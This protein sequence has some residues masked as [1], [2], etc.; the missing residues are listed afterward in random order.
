MKFLVFGLGSM[1]KRRV[2]CLKSLD[3]HDIYGFDFNIARRKET[4]EKYSIS[5]FNDLNEINF[6]EFDAFIISVPP[7][8]HI[9]YIEIAVKY[10]K[11]SFVEAGV[12]SEH[13][14]K[15]IEINKNNTFLAPSCTLKFHPI[16]KNLK[17]I[18][19]SSEYGKLTNFTFHSG[20]FLPDWH[21]WESINDFYV[22]N[23]LTGGSREI[24]PF[25]LTWITDIFG[26]PKDVKGYFRKT[27]DLKVNIEDTY[28]F[29]LDFGN[30]L[31]S[32]I[33]DVCARFAT[34]SLILNLEKAQIR[35]NWEDGFLKIFEADKNKWLI[36][37]Q[38]EG[39]AELGYNENIIEQM[40]VDEIKAFLEGIKDRTLYPNNLENDLMILELLDKI[41]D[42]DGGFNR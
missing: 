41:E 39:K 3:F 32:M 27:I 14:K 26:F 42:S 11:P 31:G 34:R 7:D 25:E 2:R 5:V 24:V 16:I 36:I 6:D 20:Q 10:N 12:I 22:G 35:W 29:L 4:K 19:S 15:A 1:G 33:V 30:A 8:K 38:P 37:H 18:I 28:S 13:T 23:R 40:Y 17:R 21:P 9:D